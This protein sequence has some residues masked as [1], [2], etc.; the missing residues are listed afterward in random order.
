MIEIIPSLLVS[1]KAEFK[2]QVAAVKDAVSM[3][4][5]D[6]A[7]G[8][9]VPNTTWAF[10]HPREAQEELDIDF[11]LHLMVSDPLTTLQAWYDN[12][13]LKRVLIHY[14]SISNVAN[15]IK[16]ITDHRSLL[17]GIVLNP[18]TPIS[19]L[20]PYLDSIQAVMFMG[21]H[22]GFQ[23]QTFIPETLDRIQAL[24]AKT[25]KQYVEIDG[26]VN[27][28]TVPDLIA[29]GVNA[30]CPGS[31]IFGK[32]DPAENVQRMRILISQLTKEQ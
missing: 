7:D 16:V 8:K 4:Q 29:A 24:K 20:D 10:S 13:R 14:E 11:E 26:G 25:P 2:S 31:A 18:E 28:D 32:G 6:L 22:P 17:I 9:F 19:V 1:S 30:V 3:I 23:G 21:V 5:I 12:H 27:E 15:T